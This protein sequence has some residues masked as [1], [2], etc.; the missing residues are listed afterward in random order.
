MQKTDVRYLRMII[1][2]ITG[3]HFI[4]STFMSPIS[5]LPQTATDA[6]ET[7]VEAVPADNV[8]AKV[9]SAP[10]SAPYRGTV[11]DVARDGTNH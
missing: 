1:I 8:L 6:V 4:S 11:P 5:A 3:F 9:H 7:I 10:A 2:I